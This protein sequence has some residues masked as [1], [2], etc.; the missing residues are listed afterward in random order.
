MTTNF[1]WGSATASYQCEGAWNED[2][3][4]PSL[5]DTYLHDN[6]L[7]NGDI[8]SDHY[9]RFKEDIQLM[10]EGGHNTYRFSL[11]WPRLITDLAGTINPKG[12]DFYHR[13]IDEC[14][15]NGIEPFITIF[16][17]DLPDYLEQRGGWLSKETIEA[18]VILCDLVF[19]EYGQKVKYW[20]T[21]NEPRYY[22]FSGY[23][24]GNY[25]PGVHNP[26]QTISASYNMML[27]NAEA[28]KRFKALAMPG[29]IGIVHSYGPIYGV[30]DRPETRQAM[31]DADNYYNNWILDTAIL[32]EIPQDM[33]AK[34]AGQGFDLGFILPEELKTIK[35][36]TVD[37]VGL[38]YYARVLIAPY[39]T[40]ETILAINNSGASGQGSSKVVVR[41]WFE[42]V[43]DHANSEFTPWDTEIY[44]QG[45]YEGILMAHKKYGVPIYITE[46][47]VGA[48]E[49][50][51]GE[52]INDQF[53]IDFLNDHIDAIKRSMADGAD[54]R[55][56]YVWS[57]MDLYS[58]KNGSEKRYGLV[59]L[60]FDQDR[61]RKPKASYYWYKAVCE[62]NGETIE[63]TRQYRQDYFSMLTIINEETN[64]KER[65]EDVFS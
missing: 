47:G 54:V 22:V 64:E 65:D 9:H 7:E 33:L 39:E 49:D 4:V 3:R 10:K 41:E 31:R 26:Q 52:V 46:N 45:L 44:P 48:Y 62:S 23:F 25:P 19:K 24:I 14:L 35:Q 38:N 17:W 16:H 51:S 42:Q 60:D 15:A 36:N 55:G 59:A 6:Q 61:Q 63:A 43:W 12:V 57:T 30:D 40:G 53:R 20:T 58:W 37:F 8:A 34:L 28:V 29:E 11:S 56:Y 21:F 18:Y 2:G 13:L 27:A 32:G 50:V 1:L 5:W